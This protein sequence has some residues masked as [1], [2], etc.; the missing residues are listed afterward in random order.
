MSGAPMLRTVGAA[1][2]PHWGAL[3]ALGLA[4]TA[5]LVA[6]NDYGVFY[7][8]IIE[9][10]RGSLTVDYALGR[11][12]ALLN[13][14]DRFYGVGFEAPLEAAKRAFGIEDTRGVHLTRHLLTRLLFLIGGLF[15]YLLTRRLLG[16][17]LL[18]L[19]ATGL[20][21]LHPLLH[22]HSFFNAKDIAFASMFMIAL[23]LTHRAF[24]RDALW[25]FAL[26]GAGAGVLMNAR[27]AGAMLI[28]AVLAM[29]ALDMRTASAPGERTR[30]LLSGGVFLGAAAL[31]L[32]AAWPYLWGDPVERFVQ[33][34]AYMARHPQDLVETFRGAA[35]WSQ[36]V[37]ADYI[38]TW[39]SLTTPPF[40]LLLGSIG[41]AV[42]LRH[43]AARPDAA[44]RNTRLR[45]WALLIGAI[46]LP[47]V[48]VV[49][50]GS[51]LYGGWRQMFFL[52]APL[53]LLG[54]FG[55]QWLLAQFGRTRL[56]RAV[57]AA[58]SAGLGAAIV[59]LALLHPFQ[60][61]YFNFFAD[62]TE[63]EG[64]S[65]QYT[66]H[67]GYWAD[68]ALRRLLHLRPAGSVALAHSQSAVRALL[69]L[70]EEERS[71]VSLVPRPLAEFSL[72]PNRP[73]D[74]ERTLA[75]ESVYGSVIWAVVEDEP[76][77][78]R[79]LA[80]YAQAV[81]SDP[82][83]QEAWD[84][85]LNRERRM[86]VYVKE[87][88]DQSIGNVHFYLLVYPDDPGDL[89]S[90]EKAAG[91]A[92]LSFNLYEF[93][94]PIEGKCVAAIPLLDHEIAG[95][96]TGQPGA[97]AWEAAFPFA[98]PEAYRAAY[99]RAMSR[100]PDA[101]GVFDVY[102]DDAERAL[103]Y[104]KEPCAPSDA[105]PLFFLHVMPERKID[106]SD[107]RRE[108]GFDNLDFEFSLRG[109][110]FD[111]KCVASVPLPDYEIA[112]ARTGQRLNGDEIWE[113]EFAVSNPPARSSGRA[114]VV[115]LH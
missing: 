111:G 17:A 53:S 92:N 108:L 94:A 1:L 44:L 104:V 110:M 7:D 72:R 95:I 21:L 39:L 45:F 43:V 114:A 90:W 105:A 2:R 89:R 91:F 52:W 51:T 98:A 82:V 81:R 64:I 101:R 49:A 56:R 15:A 62:R 84:V 23:S 77:A 13:F 40:A 79:L 88:C 14:Q 35:V 63:P 66:M 18:S 9:G 76:G 38:P 5:G 47:V 50:L 58:A 60:H 99:E 74:M 78:E 25:A 106:L 80:A 115:V 87:P 54:A 28:P 73:D 41:T 37:P 29:R 42:L 34:F 27:I 31:T 32:Y 85:Y 61:A 30:I 36:D 102:M 112:T 59:S 33:S 65:A 70:G 4:L 83:A 86:L 107:E 10:E 103:T 11:G 6:L 20:F 22:A 113:E 16:G 96:R 8:E 12:E 67:I 109:M 93:G 55:L 46:I 48:A 75:S 68:P 57:C 3:A 69:M 24:K 71:R 97:G 19:F 26:A 100:E